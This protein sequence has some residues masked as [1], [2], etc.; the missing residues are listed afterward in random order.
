[1][2]NSDFATATSLE[3]KLAQSAKRLW[4][5]RRLNFLLQVYE[6]N[7]VLLQSLIGSARDYSGAHLAHAPGQP[8]LWLE[9]IE[10]QPYTSIF[11]LTQ[12]FQQ[13]EPQSGLVFDPNA[14]VRVYHD[15]RQAEV[16]HCHL[17]ENLR[18]LFS[19]EQPIAAVR[20]QRTQMAS[21]FNKWLRFLLEKGFSAASF[22]IIDALPAYPSGPIQAPRKQIF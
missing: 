21:F 8:P 3:F 16:T 4:Q 9:V 2:E 22:D 13:L 12:S 14:F 15:T 7:F 10:Q 20:H 1:M 17:G 6:E 19:P 5:R 18:K 11:R